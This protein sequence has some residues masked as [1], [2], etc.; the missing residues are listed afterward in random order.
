MAYL[1]DVS[2]QQLVDANASA[3]AYYFEGL[4]GIGTC[5]KEKIVGS[6]TAVLA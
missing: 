6:P 5:K 4:Y 2:K 1:Q 3:I